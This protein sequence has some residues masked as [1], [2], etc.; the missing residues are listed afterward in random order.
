MLADT[1]NLSK[2]TVSRA[3]NGY[4]DISAAT[5]ERVASAARALGYQ[6]SSHARRLALGLTETV[7]FV[8]P[9]GSHQL[10]SPLLAETLSG[11]SQGLSRGGYDL[12]VRTATHDD[13]VEA[14]R[15]L[16]KARKVD[17]FV[18]VRTR[19]KDPRADYLGAAGVPFICH[20]RTGNADAHAWVEVD[21]HDAFRRATAHL[22][23]LGHR[24]IAHVTAGTRLAAAADRREGYLQAMADASL[25]CDPGW[26]VEGDLSGAAGRH[27]LGRLVALERRPTAIVCGND[28][29]A[30]GVMAAA[31]EA[32]LRVPRDLSV[33][34]YDGISLGDEVSPALTTMTYDAERLG[35]RIAELLLGYLRNGDVSSAQELHQARLLRRSSDGPP[36]ALHE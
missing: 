35:M 28:A 6:P 15:D 1:L 11:I 23:S 2:A 3:L 16:V 17:A 26:V 18:L 34:G 30:L 36:P 31:N 33:V 10:A 22:I 8:V 32:G 7:G 19:L 21:G 4:E 5:R 13:D 12:V 24:R 27:A 20:G 29:T 25:S 14:Y 9:A